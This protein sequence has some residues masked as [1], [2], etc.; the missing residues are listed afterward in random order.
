MLLEPL[1]IC[2]K[3]TPL[4][5]SPKAFME[6]ERAGLLC[7]PEQNSATFATELADAVG[8]ESATGSIR[9][10]NRTGV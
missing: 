3:S 9:G 7:R 1:M 6:L 8:K 2:S 5:I 10:L 4:F